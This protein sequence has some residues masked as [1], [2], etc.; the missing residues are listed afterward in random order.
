MGYN[1]I[2]ISTYMVYVRSTLNLVHKEIM[3]HAARGYRIWIY[4]VVAIL[5]R[6]RRRY[7]SRIHF[8]SL[9]WAYNIHFTTNK[10]WNGNDRIRP[11]FC[12]YYS[13][14]WCHYS[15]L[16]LNTSPVYELY[17]SNYIKSFVDT[18][19]RHFAASPINVTH[20]LPPPYVKV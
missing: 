14:I 10:S 2:V 7:T 17:K 16:F 19:S 20:M 11:T 3:P 9:N 15:F 6:T 13:L 5:F 18:V 8:S 1:V 4:V 12:W